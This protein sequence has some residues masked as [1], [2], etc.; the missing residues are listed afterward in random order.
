MKKLFF[1]LSFILVS[2]N[3][4][5][6][7]SVEPAITDIKVK[8]SKNYNGEYTVTNTYKK[9]I[10][11]TIQIEDWNSFPGN[12]DLNINDWLQVENHSYALAAG[13]T[14][15]IPYTV[16]IKENLKGSVS[17]RLEFFVDKNKQS[18]TV[19]ISVPLY[20]T[21]TGTEH[22]DFAVENI[23]LFNENN[24]ISFKA[25]IINNGNIH[26]R[27]SFYVEIY[28]SKKKKIIEKI[29]VSE[30]VPVYAQKSRQLQNKLLESK[31]LQKDKYHAV[32][33]IRALDKEVVKEI[34][35]KISEDGI[36]TSQETLKDNV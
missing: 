16:S 13:Q 34:V 12:T 17:A 8:P 2:C 20:V 5:A 15:T 11:V 18:R 23:T 7:L 21:V 26:I 35:F 4:F 33:K 31:K 32:F 29:N 36:I 6:G 19:S 25:D 27:P 24:D 28:D 30:T 22:L 10:D 14:I 3:L 9:P 1:I